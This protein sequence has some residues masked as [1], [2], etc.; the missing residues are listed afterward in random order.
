MR[1]NSDDLAARR[2]IGYRAPAVMIMMETISMWYLPV[3]VGIV[4]AIIISISQSLWTGCRLGGLHA[5]AAMMKRHTISM[6]Y[7]PIAIGI[8]DIVNISLTLNFRTFWRSNS[9]NGV[10]GRCWYSTRACHITQIASGC[11][12]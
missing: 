2:L 1:R 6:M 4:S 12:R 5:S 8:M 9:C 3:T 10:C 11:W 7:S